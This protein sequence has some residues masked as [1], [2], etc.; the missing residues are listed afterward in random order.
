MTSIAVRPPGEQREVRFVGLLGSAAYRQ[1]VFAI[2]VIG[3]RAHEVVARVGATIE[4]HTG[5]AVRNV[6]ET[7]PRDV[8]FEAG[9]E[10]LTEL[11]GAIV[12]LQE[13]RIVRVF[14]VREP[15]GPWTTVLAYVPQTAVHR[16]TARAGRRARGRVLRRRDP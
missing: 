10:E 9:I 1:S 8:V 7:L 12:G 3:E 14:D 11:V 15:V 5:R 16:C 13:R 6:I 2:P 4:S